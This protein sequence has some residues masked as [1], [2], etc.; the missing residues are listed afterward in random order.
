M[1]SV[2]YPL[3]KL[4]RLSGF[5][6]PLDEIG[7]MVNHFSWHRNRLID[8]YFI[9]MSYN[10]EKYNSSAINSQPS[11]SII[12]P[13][14]VLNSTVE[15]RHDELFFSYSK[16]ISEKL[17]AVFDPLSQERRH[18]KFLPD[19]AFKQNLTE[20]REL[21]NSR[22][23]LGTADILD[24]LAMRMI[25]GMIADRT[26]P[27]AGIKSETVGT[28]V[29]AIA[30]QLKR[31]AKLESLIRQ[32]GYS[33]RAFYYEWNR[34]FSVSPKQLQLEAKLEK[35]QKLLVNTMLPIAEIAQD[36]GFSSLRYFYEC[37]L[38]HFL[39]TPGEYRKRYNPGN[40]NRNQSTELK[41]ERL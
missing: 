31:G 37:F 25:L 34:N 19:A 1:E 21:L 2:I 6:F 32:Y 24:S 13:G 36:C 22:M 30:V 18:F 29:Q 16:E 39:R 28:K 20:I 26:V 41:P 23:E 10:K 5:P 17:K 35:A 8:R 4:K 12:Q 15:I 38:R 11:F 14:T 7:L 33:R 40:Q 3:H 27:S 9:C